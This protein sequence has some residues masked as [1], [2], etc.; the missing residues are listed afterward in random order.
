MSL[1][2]HFESNLKDYE[3]LVAFDTMTHLEKYDIF[4]RSRSYYEKIFHEYM[5]SIIL[6]NKS[7]NMETHIIVAS[8]HDDDPFG[9]ED[10]TES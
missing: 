3:E 7:K 8:E 5:S 1:K 4:W 9:N 2:S 6:E 10:I